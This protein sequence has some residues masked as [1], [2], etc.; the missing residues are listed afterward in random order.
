MAIKWLICIWSRDITGVLSKL[1]ISFYEC[2]LMTF[3]SHLFWQNLN[4]GCI[5][6]FFKTQLL[7]HIFGDAPMV[8]SRC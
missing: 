5:Y 6:S 1:G 4:L 2:E 3:V 8:D 7:P